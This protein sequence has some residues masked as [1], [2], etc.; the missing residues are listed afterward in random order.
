MVLQYFQQWTNTVRLLSVLSVPSVLS[1]LSV[2]LPEIV[3]V[4]QYTHEFR[5][6][7]VVHGRDQHQFRHAH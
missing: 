2:S 1:V 5:L 4:R 7:K 6:G 3:P